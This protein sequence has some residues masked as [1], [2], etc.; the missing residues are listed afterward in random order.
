MER[1]L[2]DY[3]PYV[4]RVY[5]EF[6]AIMAGEQPELERVW[7]AVDGLLEDQFLLTA[8]DAGLSRWEKMLQ[9]VPKATDGLEDRRFRILTRLNEELPYSL[10]QLRNILGT[11]CGPGN[12]SAA[13]EDGYTLDVKLGLAAKNNYNDVAA[14]L[15]R[16]S[17]QNL[18]LRLS[19]LY[20]THQ[21]AGRFPHAQLA[22]RTHDQIRNEVFGNG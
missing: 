20:N 12:F 7:V 17:P 6:Q 19:Q 8:G 11:L 2:I 21:E 15:E 1:R 18:V 9:I 22:A 10:S 13:V 4:V 14:L 5:A 16:V 3:L